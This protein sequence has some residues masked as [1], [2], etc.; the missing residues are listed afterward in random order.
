MCALRYLPWVSPVICG[1]FG[2]GCG[3]AGTDGGPGGDVGGEGG[4]GIAY[5]SQKWSTMQRDKSGWLRT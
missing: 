1:G 2:G 5:M 3:G 4:E